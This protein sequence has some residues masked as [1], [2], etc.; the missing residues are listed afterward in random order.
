MKW[1]QAHLRVMSRLFELGLFDEVNACYR[2]YCLEGTPSAYEEFLNLVVKG[3]VKL[4]CDALNAEKLAKN[5]LKTNTIVTYYYKAV[6]GF[7]MF[8][9]LQDVDGIKLHYVAAI[10]EMPACCYQV[11]F[12]PNGELKSDVLANAVKK[13][14]FN[15][16]PKGF[17]GIFIRFNLK[18][19]LIKNN[20]ILSRLTDFDSFDDEKL[21]FTSELAQDTIADS[22]YGQSISVNAGNKAQ[23]SVPKS[24]LTSKKINYFNIDSNLDSGFGLLKVIDLLGM[25]LL[26]V[27]QRRQY[28][29]N[30]FR[31]DDL[32]SNYKAL[33]LVNSDDLVRLHDNAVLACSDFESA[34][35]E[36]LKSNGQFS[37][38]NTLVKAYVVRNNALYQY[39]C[40]FCDLFTRL[41]PN[42]HCTNKD[43]SW[44]VE[45][46]YF[47]LYEPFMQLSYLQVK[48]F[49]NVS[50]LLGLDLNLIKGLAEPI[51]YDKEII[52]VVV[53][54]LP[55]NIYEVCAHFSPSYKNTKLSHP[56]SVNFADIVSSV[57]SYGPSLNYATPTLPYPIKEESVFDID[58]CGAPSWLQRDLYK[59]SDVHE[60]LAYEVI[61]NPQPIVFSRK[62]N[63]YFDMFCVVSNLV[64]HYNDFYLKS[65]CNANTKLMSDPKVRFAFD[66]SY[67][68]KY[69]V[70]NLYPTYEKLLKDE[71]F[72]ALIEC[73]QACFDHLLLILDLQGD[74]HLLYEDGYMANMLRKTNK[75][76]QELADSLATGHASSNRPSLTKAEQLLLNKSC[77]SF[78]QACNE[79]CQISKELANKT[80]EID[81]FIS[82][83]FKTFIASKSLVVNSINN[84]CSIPIMVLSQYALM[85]LE[86]VPEELKLKVAD[87][88]KNDL[89]D[90][91][92]AES[93]L[94]RNFYKCV[95]ET[96]LA[97]SA[98]D[99]Y[100]FIKCAI[101]YINLATKEDF[102]QSL[103]N[104]CLIF[105]RNSLLRNFN[106]V[107]IIAYKR[108]LQTY[109]NEQAINKHICSNPFFVNSI[110]NLMLKPY[111]L[112]L[113]YDL[114][115]LV[116]Y[117]V[118]TVLYFTRVKQVEEYQDCL[119]ATYNM[120]FKLAKFLSSNLAKI[121]NLDALIWQGNVLLSERF[122]YKSYLS[123]IVDLFT[124]LESL[125]LKYKNLDSE[126]GSIMNYCG[127]ARFLKL[128][129]DLL[130]DTPKVLQCLDVKFFENLGTPNHM[131]IPYFNED[132]YVSYTANY[133]NFIMALCGERL[134]HNQLDVVDYYFGEEVFS[135]IKSEDNAYYGEA[136]EEF[137]FFAFSRRRPHEKGL[138][139]TN[140]RII[141]L[142][143]DNMRLLDDEE[144]HQFLNLESQ[145]I[146][147]EFVDSS[148]STTNGKP[149]AKAASKSKSA[150]TK[151]KAIKAIAL[152]SS[153]GDACADA[154]IEAEPKPKAKSKATRAKAK[155]AQQ[156]DV[157]DDTTEIKSKPKAKNA[158][159]TNATKG[160][161]KKVAAT[162]S[163][164]AKADE[165]IEAAKDAQTKP[166]KQAT[167]A[168][169][170]ATAG[171]TTTTTTTSRASSSTSAK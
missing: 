54:S 92:M 101:P 158:T 50:N 43:N 106:Y 35:T 27:A 28:L 171:A 23:S 69:V 97:V 114:I 170:T 93:E 131:E 63:V 60:L 150:T 62:L 165:A 152:E 2:K 78:I 100:S 84:V 4:Y 163:A 79:I 71:T 55:T 90:D 8:K 74:I 99:M 51:S 67:L 72:Q 46:Y 140:I 162:A 98:K 6:A 128:Y 145:K 103:H 147:T 167:R 169:K 155:N 18:S 52:N 166:K 59:L 44:E 49:T 32:R 30:C 85:D 76:D 108:F 136:E 95:H 146:A 102:V 83:T 12:E 29:F 89:T 123:E 61:N 126:L 47:N 153:E 22:Y 13:Q 53:E 31:C 94:T 57:M 135:I 168:K 111:S 33:E 16:S 42:Y 143:M 129:K 117:F 148:S 73:H 157:V 156:A 58:D 118:R 20:F 82:K 26:L 34:R 45:Y 40:Y 75:Y 9:A 121:R 132:D 88:V 109:A 151:S 65:I 161:A 115:A 144:L 141:H 25:N 14:A 36:L 137:F 134:S 21:I 110:L 159:K 86:N 96:F 11:L 77:I 38:I 130:E 112:T 107:V 138:T 119:N 24:T 154:V 68:E 124:M 39:I 37:Y 113:K 66:L 104:L 17:V 70:K 87:S 120:V 149:K 125:C 19:Y 160:R 1:Y 64:E 7:A 80:T 15:G 41:K 91:G 127:I 164:E 133:N 10:E 142:I 81:N 122:E 56:R 105:N 48:L 3:D 139:K 5:V 116:K